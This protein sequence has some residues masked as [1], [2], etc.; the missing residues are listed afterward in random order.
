M[1]A[2]PFGTASAY[3]DSFPAAPPKQVTV[4]AETCFNLS[5]FR[6]I[7]R[8][9]RKL[10]D[11]IIIRLNRAQAQLRDQDRLQSI[12]SASASSSSS[13]SSSLK[14][15]GSEGMCAKL[16][17]EMMAGWAH[18]QTLLT[19]CSETVN[20][21]LS[22]KTEIDQNPNKSTPRWER[23]IKEEEVLADQLES[24]QSIE[25]I[26]RKRTLDAF[27]SRCQ[28]F[29]PPPSD[30][31]SRAWWDLADHGKKGKGPDLA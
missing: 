14:M 15:S 2:P 31:I 21:S 9:Y 7:V 8:Q 18:R 28:F 23:G 13:S 1:P 4:T 19:F 12:P 6:D 30:Q 16:W 5:V 11:Q 22:H 25:A 24:E 3:T 20:D 17:Q 29:S 27:K 26:I 10:D